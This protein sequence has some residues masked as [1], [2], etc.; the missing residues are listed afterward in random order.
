MNTKPKPSPGNGKRIIRLERCET[1][2]HSETTGLPG[3]L[4]C[5]FDLPRTT[6]F[7][8]PPPRPGMPDQIKEHTYFP[9]VK[10][11]AWCGKFEKGLIK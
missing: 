7:I 2:K 10:P 5:R 4:E 9:K 11:D 6:V 8:G 1:C 3:V